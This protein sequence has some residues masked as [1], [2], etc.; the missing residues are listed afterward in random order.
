VCGAASNACSS[1][2]CV[3]AGKYKAKMCAVKNTTPSAGYCTA[4]D[5]PVCTTVDFDLPGA[6]TVQGTIGN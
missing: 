2:Q 1:D 4:G 5:S 3:P 6:T